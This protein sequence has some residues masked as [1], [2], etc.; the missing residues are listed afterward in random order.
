MEKYYNSKV[1][2]TSFRPGDK[3]YRSN[4]ASHAKDGGLGPKWEGPYE[5]TE[6]L[7]KGAYKLKDRNGNELLRTQNICNL[8]KCYMHEVPQSVSSSSKSSSGESGRGNTSFH[9]PQSGR[10]EARDYLHIELANEAAA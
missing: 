6:S 8:K 4:D 5:V 1:Q 3:V 7:G 2:S 10:T 9:P